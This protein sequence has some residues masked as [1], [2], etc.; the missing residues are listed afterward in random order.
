MD[1]TSICDQLGKLEKLSSCLD[2]SPTLR[3]R[4]NEQVKQITDSFYRDLPYLNAYSGEHSPSGGPIVPDLNARDDFGCTIRQLHDA[5][6]TR[7]IQTAGPGHLGFIPGG[8]LHIGAIADYLGACYNHFSADSYASPAAVEIHN[9]VV[10]WLIELVGYPRDA[11]GDITSGGS[12]ATVQAFITA[13]ESLEIPPKD[14]EKLVFYAS[15][16]SHHCYRKAIWAIFGRTPQI[17]I[18]ETCDHR[19]DPD[20]FATAIER[21]LKAGLK[22]GLLAAS[23]G[24]TN[25]GL[26]DPLAKLGRICAKNKIWFHVDGA[27]GGFFKLTESAKE[28]F[29]GMSQADSIILDPHKGMFLPYGSG[30]LLVKNGSL[31]VKALGSEETAT[32]LQDRT[33]DRRELSPMDCS[34]ELSRPFRSLRLWLALKI[35]GASSFT[36]ALEEKLLLAKLAAAK[37]DEV[38]CLEVISKPQLS[39]FAFRFRND[40]RD[41]KT[42]HLLSALNKTGDSFLSST[43]IDGRFVIRVAILAHRT[44]L[45]TIEK[46][47]SNIQTYCKEAN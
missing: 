37:I 21:D 43:K 3:A 32:Y 28:H 13:R 8:G 45:K 46:L 23:A 15:E 1:K 20:G 29:A 39:I 11:V 10:D 33:V 26:I 7:G 40:P 6:I 24:T 34:L 12:H 47:V 44:H 18:L 14:Y 5:L 35:H 16:H 36:A 22:P 2:P 41:E 27:Y 9:Q 17:R 38:S 4:W 30:A 31:M 25:L 19:I 42:R